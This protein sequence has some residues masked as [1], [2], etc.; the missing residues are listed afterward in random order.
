MSPSNLYT[1]PTMPPLI[2]SH[3]ACRGHAPENTLAG[4]RTALRL[5]ADGI[6]VD[7]RCT[8]DDVPVLLHDDTVSRTTDGEGEIAELSLRQAR[9][10]DVGRGERIPT[11]RELLR[12]VDG[13]ALL[14]LEVKVAG[15]EE[16]VLGVVRRARALD[17][18]VVHSFLPHVVKRFRKLEPR[19]PASLLATGRNV[20]DW[21]RLLGDT[22]ELGAQ[23]IAIH[24]SAVTSE[25]VR[26][27]HLRELRIST[28]TAN[29]RI[30]IRR[31][32][33]CGVDAVT[34]DYPDRARRWLPKR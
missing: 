32:A 24:H 7:L 28:W 10:L 23:G 30:D 22:L 6:E 4:V 16:A 25:I 26:A 19:L 3:R 29:R 33:A 9:R 1:D 11:L 27:A 13:K 8:R 5:G 31:V 12:T 2:V 15:I 21:P 18:C 14:V 20:R 17:F 34:S